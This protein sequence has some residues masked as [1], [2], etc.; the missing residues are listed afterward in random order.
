[1]LTHSFPWRLYAVNEMGKAAAA[2]KPITTRSGTAAARAKAPVRAKKDA[3]EGRRVNLG[4]DF[5][6]HLAKNVKELINDGVVVQRFE[7]NITSVMFLNPATQAF[8]LQS[9]PGSLQIRNLKMAVGQPQQ[10]VQNIYRYLET[11][12]VDGNVHMRLG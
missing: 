6:S 7:D 4:V 8:S 10:V 9:V 2:Q 11:R 12:V 3:A 5:G 1:M